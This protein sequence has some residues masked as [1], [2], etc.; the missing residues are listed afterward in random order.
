MA[1]K[2]PALLSSTRETLSTSMK[3][4]VYV[5]MR[6]GP[7]SK[8]CLQEVFDKYPIPNIIEFSKLHATIIY[9]RKFDRIV[10]NPEIRIE[11]VISKYKIYLTQAKKAAL[12]VEINSEGLRQRHL[13]L[14]AAYNLT[15]DF[16]S[17]I[18]H[19]TL[20]YDV[21][22]SFDL[23]K[24]PL[25]DCHIYFENEYSEPLDLEWANTPK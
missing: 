2:K 15:Y 4:G 10:V 9:S 23:E 14:M 20:S 16:E 13:E 7:K 21:G 24:L 11:G 25:P 17:Y 18:P 6:V 5:A 12:V 8:K 3:V 19:F 1:I 22:H